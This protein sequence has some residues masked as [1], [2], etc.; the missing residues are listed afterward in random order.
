MTTHSFAVERLEDVYD[1]RVRE[2]AEGNETVLATC[3]AAVSI[4]A[5]PNSISRLLRTVRVQNLMFYNSAN[6]YQVRTAVSSHI[7]PA[8]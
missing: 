7:Y 2:Y 6:V 1:T 5:A 3:R 4:G 8:P